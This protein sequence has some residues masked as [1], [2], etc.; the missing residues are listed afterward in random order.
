[1]PAWDVDPWME[2]EA[3]ETARLDA[4]LEMAEMAAAG[5]AIHAARKAGRCAHQGV[6]GYSGGERRPEQAG[7]KVGQL[8]CTDGC[9][10]IFAD[11]EAWY[12]AMDAAVS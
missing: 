10:A 12:A 1:M 9:S 11:D 4:D 3:A 8:R 2:E 5:D 7:L 6:Q